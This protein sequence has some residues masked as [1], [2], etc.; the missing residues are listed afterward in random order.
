[1]NSKL[2]S[3]YWDSCV[4]IDGHQKTP[5]RIPHILEIEKTAKQGKYRIITSTLAIAEVVKIPNRPMLTVSEEKQIREYFLNRWVSLVPLDRPVATEAA[6]LVRNHKL[7]PPDAVRLA[8]AM[9][10]GCMALCTY[11]STSGLLGLDKAIDKFRIVKPE[12]FLKFGA[13]LFNA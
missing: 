9:R 1:M 10:C 12:D 7:K 5:G 8:T 6:A 3:I 4:F 2:P 13:E 11:D